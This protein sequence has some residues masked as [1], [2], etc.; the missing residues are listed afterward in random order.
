MTRL[1]MKNT[2]KNEQFLE[3]TS[4]FSKTAGYKIQNYYISKLTYTA[5]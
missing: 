1:C 3:L 5:E 4:K 2:P